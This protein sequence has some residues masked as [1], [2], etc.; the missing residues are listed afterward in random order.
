[1]HSKGWEYGVY[2]AAFEVM[3]PA[4]GLSLSQSSRFHFLT[5]ILLVLV[6]VEEQ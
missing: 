2:G 6:S 3:G 5:H 4:S 1:M